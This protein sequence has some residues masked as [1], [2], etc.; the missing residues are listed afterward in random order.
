MVSVLALG[1]TIVLYDGSPMMPHTLAIWD[2]IAKLRV[3]VFGTSA[4][5]LLTLSD[6]G[7]D[8]SLSVAP[9]REAYCLFSL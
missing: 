2:Y 9:Y 3:T 1:A 7:S 6:L 4:K 8:P 5:Y